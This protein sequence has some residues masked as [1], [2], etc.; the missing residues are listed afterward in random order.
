MTEIIR[1]SLLAGLLVALLFA[2]IQMKRQK[3]ITKIVNDKF[4]TNIENLLNKL[5][6]DKEDDKK[7][8]K[9]VLRVL[10]KIEESI[11]DKK[12]NS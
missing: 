10:H 11:D 8:K 12:T 3:K 9:E 2:Y 7:F 1:F 6:D 4:V 5:A